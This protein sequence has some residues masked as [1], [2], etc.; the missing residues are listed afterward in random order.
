MG[1]NGGGAVDDERSSR[2]DNQ[3]TSIQH[4]TKEDQ[5]MVT[6]F[7]PTSTILA[8]ADN[9]STLPLSSR[10]CRSALGSMVLGFGAAATLKPTLKRTTKRDRIS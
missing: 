9:A 6:H 5:G 8:E 4:E 1:G 10:S 7:S 2:A 3:H